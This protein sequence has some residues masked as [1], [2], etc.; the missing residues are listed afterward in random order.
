MTI[1]HV[2]TGGAV[3]PQITATSSLQDALIMDPQATEY[4][5]QTMEC[6]YAAG[7]RPKSIPVADQEHSSFVAPILGHEQ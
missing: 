2:D 5:P 3:I 4:A 6:Y 7:P 1:D